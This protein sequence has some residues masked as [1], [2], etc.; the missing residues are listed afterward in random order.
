MLG[1][2]YTAYLGQALLRIEAKLLYVLQVCYKTCI[3]QIIY[4]SL[5]E[6]VTVKLLV[7]L[8]YPGRQLFSPS[9]L[10]CRV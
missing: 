2:L 3:F 1:D 4:W 8:T 7:A 5:L 6:F 10:P 9:P